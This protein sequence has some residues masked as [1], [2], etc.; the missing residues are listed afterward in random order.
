M[1]AK[2]ELLPFDADPPAPTIKDKG[3]PKA[4]DKAEG[5]EPPP[6]V[7]VTLQRKPPAP[8][9][10]PELV[11]VIAPPA[12]PPATTK[13]STDTGAA[14]VHKIEAML[15]SITQWLQQHTKC[16]YLF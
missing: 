2:V 14:G 13:K 11:L 5:K 15:L 10:P 6:P 12:P 1:V 4:T 16:L 7:A 9:P 8:P 3:K